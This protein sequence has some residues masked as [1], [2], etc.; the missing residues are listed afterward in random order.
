MEAAE[1]VGTF[2]G[3]LRGVFWL[4][5][6]L[7]LSAFCSASETAVTATGR[8]KLLALQ[9][10][11]PFF[12]PLFQWLLDNVHRVLTLCLI[13]NNVVNIGA[14][15]LATAMVLDLFGP[16]G[17]VYV[18]PVMTLLIVVFGEIL[19]KSAAVAYAENALLFCAPIL[20]VLDFLLYP[21]TRLLEGTVSA[22]GWLLRMDLRQQGPFMTREEIEQVVAI[23]EESGALEAVERR[24]IHG[25]IDFEETRIYEIM[26]P[27]V[28]MVA[29]ESSTS[30]SAALEVFIEHGHSRLPVYE[31]SPDNIVGILYVKDTLKS[32]LAGDLERDVGSLVRKPMFVPESIR[33]VELL[34]SM[35]RDHVHFAVAV[36][37]YGGV[38]GIVTL[39]DLLEEIVGEIQDEYDQ[40]VPAVSEEEGGTYLVQGSV[41]LENLN[42]ALDC[43]FESEDAE[44]IAGLV[45][46]LA[47]KFPQ[48]GDALEY[49]NWRIHVVDL[50]DH[51]IKQLRLERKRP[52]G[53]EPEAD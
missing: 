5:A 25:V 22:L 31:D 28:D 35:R 37:E 29:L 15:T 47:G 34:E 24:M 18:V 42:E 33:T 26:V 21:F 8:G 2:A 19:P 50:E 30:M 41:S 45:L 23:G 40:E 39:E 20:R 27:R 52:T 7:A 32:L 46:S 11:R 6:L 14:S 10:T 13:A 9:E 36:D 48:R 43:S 16:G 17:M 3:L 4:A 1:V 53:A 38:A 51:R 44:S 12:K 49:G